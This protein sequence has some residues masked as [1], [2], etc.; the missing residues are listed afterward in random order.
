MAPEK[1]VEFLLSP[2]PD[3]HF[4]VFRTGRILMRK[5]KN[6]SQEI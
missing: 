2:M 6:E 4:A 1:N 3:F 5:I